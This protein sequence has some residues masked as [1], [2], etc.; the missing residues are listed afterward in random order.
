MS[1]KNEPQQRSSLQEA[2]NTWNTPA[3]IDRHRSMTP[4]QRVKRS[5]ELSRVALRFAAG[6]RDGA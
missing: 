3:D 1:S 4:E 2:P 5:V 6:R